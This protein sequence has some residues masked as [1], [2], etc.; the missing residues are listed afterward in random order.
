MCKVRQTQDQI[1]EFGCTQLEIFKKTCKISIQGGVK[2]RK[3]SSL[4]INW[5]SSFLSFFL[6]APTAATY[7]F[8]SLTFTPTIISLKPCALNVEFQHFVASCNISDWDLI[9]CPYFCWNNGYGVKAGPKIG[10]RQRYFMDYSIR[11]SIW[12]QTFFKPK[13]NHWWRWCKV[14]LSFRRFSSLLDTRWVWVWEDFTTLTPFLWFVKKIGLC[15][16]V[17]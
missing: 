1:T 14:W 8:T 7:I 4:V 13:S 15:I 17:H 5:V 16:A 11:C 9:K 10:W 12:A 2:L 3:P 6:G